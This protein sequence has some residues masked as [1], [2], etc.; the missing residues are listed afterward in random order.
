VLPGTTGRE[1][2]SRAKLAGAVG[3]WGLHAVGGVANGGIPLWRFMGSV[4]LYG[5]DEVDLLG[6][7]F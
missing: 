4:E 7:V 1:E 3:W 2:S 5:E 6:A